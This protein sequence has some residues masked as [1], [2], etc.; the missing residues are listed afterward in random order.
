MY[1]LMSMRI[2]ASSLSNMYLANARASSVLPTPVG[3]KKMKDPI[4]FFGSFK[5]TLLRW[6]AFVTFPI[7]SGWP[8]TIAFISSPMRRS[9]CVSASTI[10]FTGIPV[11]MLT[12]SAIASSSIGYLLFLLSSSHVILAFSKASP[13]RFSVSRKAAA[14]SKR[15]LFTTLFFSSLISSIFFSSSRISSGTL[16]F[17]K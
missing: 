15:W 2:N 5:P 9:F 16:I 10:R 6:I 1:S 12:T 3:P 14:S 4:G 13:K 17:F 7:A 11:I 8:T